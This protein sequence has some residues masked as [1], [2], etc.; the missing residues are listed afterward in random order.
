MAQLQIQRKD[1]FSNRRRDYKVYVDGIKVGAISPGETKSLEIDPGKHEVFCKIDW[2]ASPTITT[3]VTNDSVKTLLVGG[4][5]GG[6]LLWRIMVVVLVVHFILKLAFHIEY[7]ALFAI[8]VCLIG[9]YY[10]TF[11]RKKYL[12]LIEQ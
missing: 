7:V 10:V 1:E 5:K 11:G 9:V 12:S 6:N 4:F 3:E 2:C 8:P